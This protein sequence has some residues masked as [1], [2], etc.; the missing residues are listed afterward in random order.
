[1]WNSWTLQCLKTL[2]GHVDNVRV[3]AVGE[4]HFSASY[5]HQHH[6]LLLVTAAA[7]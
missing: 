1:M 5:L 2:E 4:R 7:R 6:L 3:L